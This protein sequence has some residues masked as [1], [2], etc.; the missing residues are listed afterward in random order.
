MTIGDLKEVSK[1]GI[2]L[3]GVIFIVIPGIVFAGMLY[4]QTDETT[5]DILVGNYNDS[6]PDN[7]GTLGIPAWPITVASTTDINDVKMRLKLKTTGTFVNNA[8]YWYVGLYDTSAGANLCG[9]KNNLLF[10]FSAHTNDAYQEVEFDLNGC[11]NHMLTSV[12][13]SI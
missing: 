8:E 4:D 3:L 6:A 1:P 10:P 11:G 2:L 7:A 13:M 9:A 5:T 12:T